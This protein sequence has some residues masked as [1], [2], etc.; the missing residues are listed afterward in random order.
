MVFRGT[1]TRTVFPRERVDK[2]LDLFEELLSQW[3]TTRSTELDS[4]SRIK[5]KQPIISKDDQRHETSIVQAVSEILSVPIDDISP[6]SSLLSL[7]MDSLKSVALSRKL[8]SAGIELTPVTI[9]RHPTIEALEEFTRRKTLPSQSK[10]TADPELW[11]RD[12]QS[13]LSED[14][15]MELQTVSED[16]IL[17]WFPTTT[18]QAGLLSQVGRQA[19]SRG[20]PLISIDSCFRRSFLCTP[21]RFRI[22]PGS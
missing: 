6:N 3:N 10:A 13:S 14:D 5:S 20:S 15:R 16:E 22:P 2:L 1:Y 19:I 7:G 17:T 18:L 9:M 12:L 8:R 11:R 21:I 4:Q